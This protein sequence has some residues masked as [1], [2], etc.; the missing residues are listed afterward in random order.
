MTQSIETEIVT[1]EPRSL[2]AELNH[3]FEDLGAFP[4]A[5]ATSGSPLASTLALRIAPTDLVDAGPAF[6]LDVE[7]PGIPKDR[8]EVSL[9]GT[10]L[11]VR[12]EAAESKESAEKGWVHRERSYAGFFRAI[13]LPEPV[14][15]DE[16]TATVKDGVLHLKLPK[17]TPTPT[18][19]EVKVPVQ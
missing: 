3:L 14:K 15:S 5:R 6:E 13:E 4:F 19:G 16:A 9:R 11:A 1:W 10:H 7:I 17:L 8:L 12:G 18:P 2:F